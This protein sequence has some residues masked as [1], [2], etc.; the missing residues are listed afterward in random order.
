[1]PEIDME[2][3]EVSPEFAEVLVEVPKSRRMPRPKL[4]PTKES[5]KDK[6]GK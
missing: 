1:M 5:V 6:K 2:A 3:E 4:N